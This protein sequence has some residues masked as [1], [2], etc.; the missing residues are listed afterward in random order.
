MKG[1]LMLFIFI[2]QRSLKMT[3]VI[4]VHSLR[5]GGLIEHNFKHIPPSKITPKQCSSL[6][7][8]IITRKLL[9]PCFMVL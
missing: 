7:K 5:R 6:V 4:K 9:L 8:I 2:G 3:C 1:R